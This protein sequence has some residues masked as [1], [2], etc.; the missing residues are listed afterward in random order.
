MNKGLYIHVPFCRRKCVYCDFYSLAGKEDIIDEYVKAVVRNIRIAGGSFDTVYFGG[1]TPSLLSGRQIYDILSAAD[2]AE[3]SEI[4]A[5]IN[6]DSADLPKLREFKSAGINRISIGIQSLDDRELSILGRLHNSEQAVN[7][8][9]SVQ[10][11][12]F[13]NISA[14]LMLGLPYQLTETVL[15]HIEK[16]SALGIK[17]ISAY[18][19]KIESGT[20]LSDN[21]ELI[22]NIAD[23][24]LSA[25]M[26][27][28][29]VSCLEKNGF[30]QY[31]ISNF[32]KAGYECKH[33]LKYWRCEDYLGIGPSAHSCMD[34]KR[35]AVTKDI[36]GFINSRKQEE[37]VTDNS[38]CGISERL[39]LALRLSEGFL[40]SQA[41][42]YAES[43]RAAAVPMEK[44]GLLKINDGR[45]MLTPNGFL[46]SNEIICRLSEVFDEGEDL[47]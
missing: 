20:P 37:I 16:L 26:Y 21:R 15:Q 14:D 29:A 1:G 46:V 23:E 39:M 19:L 13:D 33:N 35:F 4:S 43:V 32:A 41:Q 34:G 36:Y 31:E 44:H 10:N 18:M 7:A 47:G 9:L 25:D 27:L 40:L 17:H 6:P 8:I 24:E 3:N 5:E 11:A 38:P 30:K 28:E 42:E 12:G 45:I 2:I 22:S